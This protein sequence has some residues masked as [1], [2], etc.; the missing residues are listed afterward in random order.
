[1]QTS[2]SRIHQPY[3][4]NGA[5][6]RDGADVSFQDIV[7]I[8][9]FRTITVG[10][11]VTAEQQQIAANLFF[12]A[13]CD[14]ME[15][16][17]VPESVISLNGSL[18]LAFG[19]G[20]Q[21]H[22]SA[23]YD[24]RSKRLALAKN[25]G[26]G[27]LAHEWFHAFDHYICDKLFI[28]VSHEQFASQCWLQDSSQISHTLNEKL[29]SCFESIFLVTDK[30]QPNEYVNRS[31]QADK[32]LKTFYYARPQE[33]AARAFEACIQDHCIKN[34]F[35]VQGTKQS[36]EAK[37]GIYPAQGLRATISRTFLDYFCHLG[38]ALN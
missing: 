32:L 34:A 3:Y 23:H 14:L 1:M 11:W 2:D 36:P 6:H 20:G 5:S 10:K 8:F 27:A 26:G 13:L 37:M 15:I 35:L 17:Q 29:S 24:S 33:L 21:K 31:A 28:Q 19:S 4:R 18:S 30:S 16:L 22:S 9:D 7:K 38:Q 25:A 12:D